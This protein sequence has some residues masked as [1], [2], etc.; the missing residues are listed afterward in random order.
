MLFRSSALIALLLSAQILVA[1]DSSLPEYVPPNTKILIGIEVRGILDSDWGKQ[2]V[3][4]VKSAAGSDLLKQAAITGFD[5][6]KDVD[7]VWIAGSSLDNK[8]PTLAILR[9]RF[10]KSRLPKAIGR[11]R[12]VPLIP[13][14]G[15]RRQLMALV[16]SSTILAGDRYVVE[17]A[18][19]RH[20]SRFVPDAH[21][22]A[23]AAELRKRYWIWAE[24]SHLDG[25][26]APKGAPQGIGAMDSFEFGL[27]LNHNLEMAAQL[28][29]Q[30]AADA[31][32]LL[33]TLAM[34]QMMA[35]QQ[36]GESQARI[37]THVT[38][39]TVDV[40]LTVPESELK[41][42]W[43]QQRAAIAQNLSQLPQQIAAVR[44]GGLNAFTAAR[45]AALAT[46]QNQA[47]R[48]PASKEGKIVSDPDGVTIECTLPGRN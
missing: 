15:N 28:Q 46:P 20:G 22:M 27:A 35:S 39:K 37:E 24:G 44:A 19:E 30:S 8:G 36:K 34:L 5:P 14:D 6:L 9:G 40:S 16:D 2:L 12:E 17:L 10:D 42:A 38:G 33:G 7:E 11:F 31:Q 32:K 13:M 4:Q 1:A 48:I 21:F 18:I 47:R 23:A 25:L 41:K 45:P 26:A 43:E 29:M 3:E